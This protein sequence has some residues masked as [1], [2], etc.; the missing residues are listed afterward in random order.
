MSNRPTFRWVL[1]LVALAMI[2]PGGCG[3]SNPV[4]L[5][6]KSDKEEPAEK[7]SMPEE[8]HGLDDPDPGATEVIV[9]DEYDRS[10]LE[11]YHVNPKYPSGRLMGGCRFKKGAK[12]DIPPKTP[13]K[14]EGDYAIRDPKPGE[15]KYYTQMGLNE[16][17][18]VVKH[19]RSYVPCNVVVFLRG[20]RVGPRARLR[21]P[22]MVVRNG[23]I[24][25]GSSGNH[26]GNNV[27]FSAIHER[28]QFTT[29]DEYPS[30][31]VVTKQDTGKKV[32]EGEVRYLQTPER[33]GGLKK[34]AEGKGGLIYKPELVPTPP[35]REPGAYI[36]TDRRHPWL[37]GYLFVL[38]NP[39]ATVS[40]W[41]VFRNRRCNF[42]IDNVPA[43]THTAEVWHP[44]YEPVQRVFE[45]TIH[46]DQTT[47]LLVEFEPPGK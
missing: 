37:K 17:R 7:P 44:I 14:P 47:E 24:K 23:R 26:G 16:E 39:Y 42:R 40:V 21:R 46:K 15:V 11:T 41:R 10:H 19:G 2:A 29:W 38:D 35:L 43:G 33:K 4:N 34:W 5:E 8:I 27:Q 32:F 31:I 25:A 36:V 6:P 22:V 12:V 45:V 20:V 13:I 28:V 9:K 18:W 1:S 3:E 30:R